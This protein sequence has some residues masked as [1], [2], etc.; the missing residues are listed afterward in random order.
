MHLKY[1]NKRI[2]VFKPTLEFRVWIQWKSMASLWDYSTEGT[3][4]HVTYFYI[5]FMAKSVY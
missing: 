1:I 3:I 4:F 2:I 5:I